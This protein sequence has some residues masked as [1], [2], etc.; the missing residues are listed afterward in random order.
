VSEK[1]IAFTGGGTGG[2]IYPGLA[3]AGALREKGFSGRIVWLGSKKDSD[4]AAVEAAGLEFVALA[5][6]KLR[7]QL[8]LQNAADAFR[9]LAGYAQARRELKRLKPELLFSK[10]GY[11]SVPPCAA[12]ASLGIPYF[13]HESDLTPGLATRLNAKKAEA[14]ILSYE[15]TRALLP[16][17]ARERAIAAGNPVR[18]SIRAGDRAKGRALLGLPEGM[19]VIFFLG[20]SQGARQVNELVAESLSRL[21][22]KAF[23]LHQGGP[24]AAPADTAS[25]NA[26]YR[27][28]QYIQGEMPD[29]LAAADL[30]VGR[31]GAGTLWESSAQAKPLLLVPLCGS[32]TRGDQVDNAELFVKAGAAISLVGE[33]A[34][35]AR[36]ASEALGLLGDQARL[37]SMGKAAAA[38]AGRDAASEIADII[39]RRIGGSP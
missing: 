8:S 13:T 31:A 20:G 11:V 16:E 35:A 19:P 23:V 22:E 18:A 37:L 9:V 28:Y 25:P 3:V 2:H 4:R 14:V 17:A 26:R 10:G 5:S 21:T 34:T 27:F 39:L 30:I 36:L 38:L 29:L 33:E 32:G 15:A 6:G 1:T 7:R 24:G 12:A